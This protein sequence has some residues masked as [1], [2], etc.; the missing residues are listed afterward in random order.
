LER[1]KDREGG[2]CKVQRKLGPLNGG[3]IPI[4]EGK[5]PEKD[6]RGGM[7]IFPRRG[8]VKKK[9][10]KRGEELEHQPRPK[11]ASLTDHQR[12]GRGRGLLAGTYSF[13]AK[14]EKVESARD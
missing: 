4:Q 8:E 7:A 10:N 12:R 1:G 5:D 2:W 14:K 3:S 6:C 11:N 13:P 9:I